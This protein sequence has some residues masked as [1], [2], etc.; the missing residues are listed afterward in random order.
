MNLLSII[1]IFILMGAETI[2]TDHMIFEWPFRNPLNGPF[3][4]TGFTP[5]FFM[6]KHIGTNGEWWYQY[7]T[8]RDEDNPIPAML[9]PN[10]NSAQYTSGSNVIDIVSNGIKLRAN[11]GTINGYSNNS[12]ATYFY[13]AFAPHLD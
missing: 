10:A 13:M 9:F 6:A 12:N 8:A 3:I 2:L 4:H 1:L 7:D 5:K 11:N